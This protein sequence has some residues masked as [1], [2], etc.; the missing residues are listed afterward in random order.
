M[1]EFFD[2]GPYYDYG[3]P[4][5]NP[6]S[7]YTGAGSNPPSNGN[8]PRSNDGS[9]TFEGFEWDPWAVT[10]PMNPSEG[11][12]NKKIERDIFNDLTAKAR[13]AFAKGDLETGLKLLKG[14]Y[15]GVGSDGSAELRR[16]IAS[17]EAQEFMNYFGIQGTVEALREYTDA[18]VANPPLKV[19]G[20]PPADD[21]SPAVIDPD[22]NNPLTG[23]PY[24]GGI[25]IPGLDPEATNDPNQPLTQEQLDEF[26]KNGTLPSGGEDVS[27]EVSPAQTPEEKQAEEII[28]SGGGTPEEKKSLLN[29]AIA[30]LRSGSPLGG[31][32]LLG[33]PAWLINIGRGTKPT[34]GGADPGG[35]DPGGADPGGADPGGADPGGADPGVGK[36]PGLT[37]PEQVYKH[38][39]AT[40]TTAGLTE[41]QIADAAEYAKAQPKGIV[42]NWLLALLGL[43]AVLGESNDPEPTSLQEAAARRSMQVYGNANLFDP[44]GPSPL[45]EIDPAFRNI[46]TFMP[47]GQVPDF[48]LGYRGVPGQMYANYE[49]TGPRGVAGLRG[50]IT[51]MSQAA[52]VAQGG[53]MS[54]AYGGST[55]Y[56]RMNGQIAGP[57][58]EK[59]DDIPAMLSDGEFV[60]NSAAVRGIGNLM[61]NKKPKSKAAQRREGARMMY[62]LQRAGEKAARIT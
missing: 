39:D 37:T 52:Q 23:E 32:A 60:V 45:Q 33:L 41:K 6:P 58:T 29:R 25:N 24:D 5:Y 15:S 18:D 49:G 2:S 16:F 12:F 44:T 53:L 56:P 36:F 28:N 14:A 11:Q 8:N 50:N 59:S 40:K 62:A 48:N 47:A 61:G 54:L 46:K 43:G 3:N 9:R 21:S 27:K 42:P 19:E 4:A 35:A 7:T 20:D 31:I 17:D 51:P 10:D 13:D 57:G 30:W 55:S 1:S 34:T 26:I 38:I 22:V